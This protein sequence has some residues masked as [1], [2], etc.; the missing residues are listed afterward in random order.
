ML[1]ADK[2]SG[3]DYKDIVGNVKTSTEKLDT[4][5][6]KIDAVL[7]DIRSNKSLVHELL[8]GEHGEA[9]IQD[10]RKSLDRQADELDEVRGRCGCDSH[11]NERRGH[12]G[13]HPDA[14][15]EIHIAWLT[16]AP[17]HARMSRLL[18]RG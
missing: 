14:I 15:L 5:L 1:S 17:R 13:Q 18:N 4:N 12:E 6:A 3:S 10:A 16:A 2:K 8:Y 7:A 11:G 9:T